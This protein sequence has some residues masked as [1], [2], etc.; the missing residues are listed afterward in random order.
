MPGVYECAALNESGEKG[1]SGPR[2]WNRAAVFVGKG[3]LE[4]LGRFNVVLGVEGAVGWVRESGS[5]IGV[6]VRGAFVQPAAAIARRRNREQ[7]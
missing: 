5:S 7:L 3:P 2:E 4:V 1:L 6:S